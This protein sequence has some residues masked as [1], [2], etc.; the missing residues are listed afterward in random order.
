[1]HCDC[2]APA[3]LPTRLRKTE[4]QRNLPQAVEHSLSLSCEER[5][6]EVL[7]RLQSK[8][9]G[10]RGEVI[11]QKKRTRSAVLSSRRIFA[12]FFMF[13]LR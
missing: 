1:M 12:N 8:V 9:G 2:I 10:R 13:C 3:E 5:P 7:E 4:E 6:N 11:D